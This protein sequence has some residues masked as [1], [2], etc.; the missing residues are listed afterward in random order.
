MGRHEHLH[1]GQAFVACRE[2]DEAVLLE[3]REHGFKR[4][5][6]AGLQTLDNPLSVQ[7]LHEPLQ[8]VEEL[9]E[10]AHLLP[11]LFSTGHGYHVDQR[12]PEALDL[13]LQERAVKAEQPQTRRI[14]AHFVLFQ[15]QEL[16]VLHRLHQL[17]KL[18]GRLNR[19]SRVR[20]V[21]EDTREED[22]LVVQVGKGDALSGV[23][24][25]IQ[26]GESTCQEGIR[27]EGVKQ[28][29]P[30]VG[31]HEHLLQPV[32]ATGR[33]LKYTSSALVHSA[34]EFHYAADSYSS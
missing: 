8:F 13:R 17:R 7:G 10:R 27:Q 28:G 6:R 29:V 5:H 4:V 25:F 1:Q 12:G 34:Q 24:V 30:V 11:S 3:H 19:L 2:A 26:R 23:H 20:L 14:S 18:R 32:L 16:I 31:K 21:A 33:E 15:Q 22:C 9:A